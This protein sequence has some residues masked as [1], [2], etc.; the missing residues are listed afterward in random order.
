MTR[1]KRVQEDDYERWYAD[2]SV[3]DR[4]ILS[5]KKKMSQMAF[6]IYVCLFIGIGMTAIVVVNLITRWDIAGAVLS[7]LYIVLA[8]GMQMLMLG[9]WQ[10]LK[11]EHT[12]RLHWKEEHGG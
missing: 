6:G 1:W 4:N 10:R 7:Y 11:R 12:T 2:I 5:V 8:F 9:H 3:I